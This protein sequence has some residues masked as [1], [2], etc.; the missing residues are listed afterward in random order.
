MPPVGHPNRSR[1]FILDDAVRWAYDMPCM[2][3]PHPRNR[4]VLWPLPGLIASRTF[5]THGWPDEPRSTAAMQAGDPHATESRAGGRNIPS[6][7]LDVRKEW[8]N[9]ETW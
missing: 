9:Q 5:L 4:I 3:F 7:A 8:Q 2:G 6:Q 1:G